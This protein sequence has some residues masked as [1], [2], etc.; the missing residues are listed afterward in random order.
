MASPPTSI[1]DSQLQLSPAEIQLL[2]YHQHIANNNSRSSRAASAA[3]SQGRLLLDP[4]SLAALSAHFDRLIAT[5][6]QR[7]TEVSFHHA[8]FSPLCGASVANMNS[9]SS[10]PNLKPQ[11]K[12]NMIDLEM[13]CRWR[14]PKLRDF[15]RYSGKY[16]N[17]RRNGT[18]SDALVILSG[19]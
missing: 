5:I 18:K 3:S 15:K 11:R 4:S 9:A 2:R 6:Q 13:S 8:S 17:C 14:M 12:L 1:P 7:W 16:K 10:M 19:D